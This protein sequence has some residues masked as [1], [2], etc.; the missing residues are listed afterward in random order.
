M[1]CEWFRSGHELLFP[2]WVD[3]R[4]GA[5][6]RGENIGHAGPKGTQGEKQTNRHDLYS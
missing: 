2:P 1:L 5:P 3:R 6:G 4:G